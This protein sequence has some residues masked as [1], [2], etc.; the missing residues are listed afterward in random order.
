MFMASSNINYESFAEHGNKLTNK[1]LKYPAY[2]G[3][4]ALVFGSYQFFDIKYFNKLLSEIKRDIRTRT[5][6]K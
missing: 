4:E 2:L 3:S 6:K 5:Y 1:Q